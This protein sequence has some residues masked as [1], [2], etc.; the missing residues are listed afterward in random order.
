MLRCLSG[1]CVCQLVFLL[2]WI[3]K[4]SSEEHMLVS[5]HLICTVSRQLTH[6]PRTEQNDSTFWWT[7]HMLSKCIQTPLPP[8]PP[9]RNYLNKS[10]WMIVTGKVKVD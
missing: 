8:L 9:C 4:W 7:A 5:V 2:S 3:K 10:I 1:V 6:R